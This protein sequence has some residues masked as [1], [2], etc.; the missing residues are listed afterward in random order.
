MNGEMLALGAVAAL[1][2]AVV[3]RRGSAASWKDRWWTSPSRPVRVLG[4][5]ASIFKVGTRFVL[6]FDSDLH[7]KS[8]YDPLL[9]WTFVVRDGRI[10]DLRATK[11][12]RSR[13]HLTRSWRVREDPWDKLVRDIRRDLQRQLKSGSA[14]WYDE[15]D[16]PVELVTIPVGT[17]LY[18]GTQAPDDFDIPDGP[19]WVS[20]GEE[21]AEWFVEW[22]EWMDEGRPRVLVYE[23][24]QPI[25]L[26]QVH[27]APSF[28][29]FLESVGT[30]GIGMREAA[31]AVCDAGYAGWHIPNSYTG[32]S[33]T[34]ICRPEDYLEL[35]EEREL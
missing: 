22:N 20:D 18:H 6:V 10:E 27:D 33:D 30:D 23:V 28:S 24:I 12:M 4:K 26:V 1:A 9:R 13:Y 3:V 11:R 5:P 34:L 15:G 8:G 16:E 31:D 14:T 19:A 35:V 17:T 7:R 29:A 32:G 25:T 2:A 21:V